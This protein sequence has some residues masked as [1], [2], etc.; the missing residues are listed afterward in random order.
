MLRYSDIKVGNIYYADLNPIRK[1]EFGDNHLSIILSKGKDKRT[2]TI[3]SL[4]S[5]SSGLGQNKMNLGIV[6]GLPKRLVEDR[7]GNPINTYVVLDQVRTVSANRIQYIKDGKKT[8]GTD[9]YIECPVDAFSFS[10]IVCELA[11]LR[12]ADLNDED[13]IGEYHKET[14]FN[15][16]VKKMIDLTYDIIKGRGIVADKKE[17]VIYFYN[18]ALAMEKG[19]L[20]DNYLKPH[21][22]KNKVLE[23]FNEI[24]LMSVK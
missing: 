6:S 11:D 15:Y 7:S 9:N 2:V 4:T 20:I 16:C 10:K 24:V 22:I 23:K 12:I 3:V 5:K 1:Y 8:D 19:F 14:F 18:N 13:A 21:D 17:E